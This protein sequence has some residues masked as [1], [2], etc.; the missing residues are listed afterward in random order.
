MECPECNKKITDPWTRTQR[1][2]HEVKCA[3]GADLQWD[4]PVVAG[5]DRPPGTIRIGPPQACGHPER[6]EGAKI[7]RI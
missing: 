6:R 2:H 7:P 5:T 4:Q 1:N 3:C